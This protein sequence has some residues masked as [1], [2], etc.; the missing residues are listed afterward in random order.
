M[1]Y[2]NQA[3]FEGLVEVANALD[4]SPLTTQL[5]EYCRLRE[6]GMRR[7]AFRA[8]DAFL[9][10]AN[11]WD[12]TTAREITQKIL[13]LNARTPHAHQFLSQPLITR[14]VKPTL[15]NWLTEDHRSQIALRWLG[16]LNRNCELLWKA[17]ALKPE[18]TPVRHLLANRLLDYV[19]FVTHHVGESV[20]CGDL[21]EAKTELANARSV[22]E[23]A[24]DPELFVRLLI[25]VKKF[26][27]LLQHWE[28]YM[29]SPSGTFPEWCMQQGYSHRFGKAYYYQN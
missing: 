26:E 5:G 2:W 10:L 20:L 3:N 6:K 15:E 22:V 8:L 29:A 16:I 17:L 18:D 11:E 19:D 24:P 28:S 21:E 14:F 12:V 25:D 4:G 27:T 7:E 1:Y 9:T 23:A 13:E